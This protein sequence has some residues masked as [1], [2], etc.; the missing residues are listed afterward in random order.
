MRRYPANYWVTLFYNGVVIGI[1][2]A[3]A[4]AYI[5]P[6]R[7]HSLAGFVTTLYFA[8]CVLVPS[9]MWLYHKVIWPR[10]T[11]RNGTGLR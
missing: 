6:F 11:R 2:P 1:W 8:M 3:A 7:Q 5:L 4:I 10:R 9:V